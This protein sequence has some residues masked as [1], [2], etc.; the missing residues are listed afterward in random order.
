MSPTIRSRLM[1]PKVISESSLLESDR[2]TE[3]MGCF[4]L[5]AACYQITHSPHVSP[6]HNCQNKNICMCDLH[7]FTD[8]DLHSVHDAKMWPLGHS[9]QRQAQHAIKVKG[10]EGLR[11]LM[12]CTDEVHV[13]AQVANAHVVFQEDAADPKEMSR[14][15]KKMGERLKNAVS[16]FKPRNSIIQ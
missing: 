12:G 6:A 4:R 2:N 13:G 11:C 9:R 14:S 5:P 1:S 15:E 3:K 16:N 7:R 10:S 8:P